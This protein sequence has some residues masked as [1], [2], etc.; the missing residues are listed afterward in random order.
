LRP[1]EKK[2]KLGG[3]GV[4]MAKLIVVVGLPGSG[5]SDYVQRLKASCPG[6]RAEDYM[7]ESNDDSC[8]FTDSR[9]YRALVRALREGKDSV[10]AEIE[11]CDTWRR[12]EVEEVIT[13]DAPG[14]TVEWHFFE[15]NPSQCEANVDSR[16]RESAAE[17]KQKIRRL[18][19]QYQIPP[20]AKVIPVWSPGGPKNA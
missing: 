12:V 17:E 19:R 2:H 7:A 18:S 15:N 16:G 11:Y 8:R 9:H 10:I 3:V 13:R 1:A 14:V 20:G 5:K 4:S 6:V